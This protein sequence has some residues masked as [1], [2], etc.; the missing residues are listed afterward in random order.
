MEG[1]T[2]T[3]DK[4]LPLT[5]H[6]ARIEPLLLSIES[7]SV[8]PPRPNASRRARLGVKSIFSDSNMEIQIQIYGNLFPADKP[9]KPWIRGDILMPANRGDGGTKSF[10]N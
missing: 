3:I 2:E 4:H 1:E 5:F 10:G 8:A 6:P 7:S 9:D